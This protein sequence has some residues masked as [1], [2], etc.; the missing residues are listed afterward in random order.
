MNYRL[1]CKYGIFYIV[2]ERKWSVR[3][4]VKMEMQ[5]NQGPFEWQPTHRNYKLNEAKE[6]L[7]EYLM[8]IKLCQ[9]TRN[10]F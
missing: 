10:N 9:L 1:Y 5:I 7:P 2:V 4:L 3:T 8:N 6:K